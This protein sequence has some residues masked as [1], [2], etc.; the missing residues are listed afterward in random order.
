MADTHLLEIGANG[1]DLVHEILNREDVVLAEV[2][3][4]DLVGGEGK[5]LVVD[6]AVA[7]LVDKLTDGLEVWLAVG[8]V[9]LDET[10]H[11]LGGAGD[12]DEDTVVDLEEAEELQ[13]LAGLG[14]DLVDTATQMSGR[15]RSRGRC[16]YPRIRTTK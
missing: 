10:E 4:D 14:G 11:L 12:L 8:D 6:L 7:T 15:S 9:G 5:A 1:D 3:L 16:T 13:N 2:L